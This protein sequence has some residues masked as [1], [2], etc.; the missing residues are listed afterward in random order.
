ML[1]PKLIQ[2]APGVVE[3]QHD[4]LGKYI[5]TVD[6]DQEGLTPELIFTENETNYKVGNTFGKVI[7]MSPY[8][9]VF[10]DDQS[11]FVPKLQTANPDTIPGTLAVFY[12]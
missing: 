2:T 3:C 1:K 12:T 8:N 5:F 11:S 6:S 7:V 4:T 10:M 9:R